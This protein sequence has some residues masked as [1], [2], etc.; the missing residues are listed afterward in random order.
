MNVIL[1]V[2]CTTGISVKCYGIRYCSLH[3]WYHCRRKGKTSFS[4]SLRNFSLRTMA[5]CLCDVS[6]REKK[7]GKCACFKGYLDHV[8]V[9]CVFVLMW[10]WVSACVYVYV[11]VPSILFNLSNLIYNLRFVFH[12]HHGCRRHLQKDTQQIIYSSPFLCGASIF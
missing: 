8:C 10:E 11:S 1:Y 12:R 7:E 9:C 4:L 3:S 2:N 6:F 5:R